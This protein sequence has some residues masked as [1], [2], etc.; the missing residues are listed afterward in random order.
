[1]TCLNESWLR[2]EIKKIDKTKQV[3]FALL[4][5][6]RMV[7]ALEKFARETGFD[8]SIYRDSL[9]DVWCYLSNNISSLNYGEI[10]RR[11]LDQAPDTEK[12]Y[13]PLTSAALNAALSVAATI[14]FLADDDVTHIV[15]AAGLARDTAALYA[16][17]V[18]A[19]PPLSL[20]FDEIMEQPLV[21]HEQRQQAVDLEFVQ[22]LPIDGSG[23]MVSVIKERS[24]RTPALLPPEISERN[25]RLK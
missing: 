12:F 25:L 16:Q 9:S 3:A 18:E 6:E 20:S 22:A 21:K 11:C 15:E 13:H 19:T 14:N 2:Q 7:P 1:M 10:A 24:A 17:A 8:S 5:C 23:Q 4:L